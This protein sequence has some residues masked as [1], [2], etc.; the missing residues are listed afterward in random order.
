MVQ[1]QHELTNVKNLVEELQR[2]QR[3]SWPQEDRAALDVISQ[4]PRSR[5]ASTEVAADQNALIDDA[6]APPRYPVDDVRETTDCQLHVPVQNMT[7]KVAKGSPLP[8]DPK[9][10]HHGNPIPPGYA[11]VTVDVIVPEYE[12]LEI[13][14]P[15][16]EGLVKLI[17]VHRYVILWRSEERRVGKECRL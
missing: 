4:R 2:Q 7:I 15:T 3:S 17:D 11:R 12:Y 13:D 1:F 8:C 14:F 10:L 6:P 9:A 16:P 5:V